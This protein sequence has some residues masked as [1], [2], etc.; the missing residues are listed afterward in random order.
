MI[1]N[2][3]GKKLETVTS[4]CVHMELIGLSTDTKPT[5]KWQG[6]RIEKNSLFLELNTGDL[7]YYTGSS[8]AKV[9]G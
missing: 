4:D 8:W 5:N 9:G 6:Q 3:N 1:T 7:Y 2:A